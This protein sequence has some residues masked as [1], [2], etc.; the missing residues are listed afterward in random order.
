MEKFL[1]PSTSGVAPSPTSAKSIVQKFF[2]REG[3]TNTGKCQICSKVY[4]YKL[5]GPTSSLKRH[6]LEKHSEKVEK[7]EKEAPKQQ[8]IKKVLTKV[9]KQQVKWNRLFQCILFYIKEFLGFQG[10]RDF[11]KCSEGL[12]QNQNKPLFSIFI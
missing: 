6:C 4:A 10:L 11:L 5:G 7:V 12:L 1:K 3:N 8:S 2:K 9:F